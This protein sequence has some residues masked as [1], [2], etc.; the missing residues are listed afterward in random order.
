MPTFAADE[1]LDEDEIF[2]D[3]L[4]K[5]ELLN[6][7]ELF[8]D[9][10]LEDELLNGTEL[11]EDEPCE[12]EIPVPLLGIEHSF[13]GLLGI[14]SAPKVAVEQVKLPFITL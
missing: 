12:E 4:L 10:L 14:G 3:E 6:G 7:A 8:D 13:L 1:L 2:E 9:E 11:F 5:D